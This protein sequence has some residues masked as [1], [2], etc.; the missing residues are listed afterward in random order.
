[1]LKQNKIAILRIAALI[2]ILSL[3]TL[4]IFEASHAGHKEHCHEE[5]CQL[6]LVLQIIHN[7]RNFISG[8]KQTDAESFHSYLKI[9]TLF[10]GTIFAAATLVTQKIKLLI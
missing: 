8:A 9:I 3:F 1:M 2:F 10:S 5:N 4:T 6:C 7:T